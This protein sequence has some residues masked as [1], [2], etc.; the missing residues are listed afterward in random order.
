MPCRLELV[1]LAFVFVG[2]G[3]DERNSVVEQIVEQSH[4]FPA[5]GE[6]TVRNAEGSI[7]IY[8]SEHPGLYLR[9]TKK[10]YSA[11]RLQKIQIKVSANA[12]SA[13]IDTIYPERPRWGFGD[14]SGLVDYV[15]VVPDTAQIKNLE[16]VN[17]EISIDDL[18]GV[19][20]VGE[21][22]LETY[23]E[24]IVALIAELA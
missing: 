13:T 8:C 17:G 16:S 3:F 9:A 4:P 18:R 6:L 20:G 11:A 21:K 12:G 24:Q 5:G 1:L 10:A 23:G 15:I 19:T 7:R 2:C 22:K 14:R